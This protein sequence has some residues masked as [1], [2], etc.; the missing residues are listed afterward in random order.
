M[1]Y[2]EQVIFKEKF[3]PVD[4]C[5]HCKTLS[6]MNEDDEKSREELFEKIG[7]GRLQWWLHAV[8]PTFSYTCKKCG[9]KWVRS[10]FGQGDRR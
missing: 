2:F 7:D 10:R 3:P 6:P 1:E 4:S 9:K 8:S 5:P